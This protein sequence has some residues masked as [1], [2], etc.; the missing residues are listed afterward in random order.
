MI[1]GTSL[2]VLGGGR[3]LVCKFRTHLADCKSK[4]QGPCNT[5]LL[6]LRAGGGGVSQ[7]CIVGGISAALCVP[8]ELS[9]S[10][11]GNFDRVK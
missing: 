7:R 1:S 6:L 3:T 9:G 8:I 4:T 2:V 10:N 5:A 11:V